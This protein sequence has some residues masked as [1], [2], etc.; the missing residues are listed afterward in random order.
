MLSPRVRQRIRWIAGLWLAWTVAGLLYITQETVPRLYRGEPV[1]WTYVLVGWM[2]GM[3][4]CAALTPAVLWLGRRWPIEQR[5][6]TALLHFL[7]SIA[8]SLAASAIEAPALM[9]L[10]VFPARTPP[11]S[12]VEGVRALLSFG[13]QGGVIRYWAVVAIQA[14]Y[15]S[16]RESKAA[17]TGGARAHRALRRPGTAADCRAA[18]R[19]QDAARR[20]GD[21][22]AARADEHDRGGA[23]SG[24]FLRIHRSHIVNVR[25]IAQLWSIAHDQS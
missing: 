20:H 18:E 11:G 16:H 24:S 25:R 14:I 1:P 6:A 7:F 3:Y 12:I 8:F 23:G 17:R 2:T 21:A 19:A 5:P 15:R 9:A 10:G 4:V 13:V 22:S